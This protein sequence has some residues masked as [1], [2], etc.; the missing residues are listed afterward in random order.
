MDENG[1][2]HVSRLRW[3]DLI[4][5]DAVA[6]KGMTTGQVDWVTIYGAKN[7]RWQFGERPNIASAIAK[8]L[9]A[10]NIVTQ[11]E[12]STFGEKSS[13]AWRDEIWT[14][15]AI[16]ILTKHTRNLLL[17][18]LLQTDNLISV[19]VDSPVRTSDSWLR[20]TFDPRSEMLGPNGYPKEYR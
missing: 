20:L 18:H 6:E 3:V 17:F 5:G 1:T 16:D 19:T 4:L 2:T 15:A 12:A 13:P 14:D 7:V 10:Q 9:I 8:D 11:K